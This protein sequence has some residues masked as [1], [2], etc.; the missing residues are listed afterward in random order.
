MKKHR[1]EQHTCFSDYAN[2]NIPSEFF[3]FASKFHVRQATK[4]KEHIRIFDSLSATTRT[5]KLAFHIYSP[6][7]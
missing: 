7:F 1:L 3:P 2:I 4:Y 6:Y 5:T